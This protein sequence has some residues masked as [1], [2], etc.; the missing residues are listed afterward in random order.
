V[1]VDK[2]HKIIDESRWVQLLLLDEVEQVC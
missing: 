2:Q 1:A